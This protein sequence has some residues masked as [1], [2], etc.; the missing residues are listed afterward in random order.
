MK[1]TK[2][3]SV[4]MISG[5]ILSACSSKKSNEAATAAAGTSN[6]E[7]AAVP[8]KVITLQKTKIARTI[9]YTATVLPYEEVNMVPSMPGRIDKIYVETGDRVS[10][11]QQLFLMDR[12]QLYQSK[13][14]LSSLQKDL[15]RLDT[16]LR[17][18]SVTQQQYDQMKTQYDVLKTNVDFMDENTL[19]R[20][21]FAG[22]ITGKYFENGEMYSGTP[23]T[24]SGRSAIVTVMQVNPLKVNVAISEQFYPLIKN[25]M[26]AIV[27]AD[28]Y[29]GEIFTGRVFRKAP[30]V[31]SV[32]RS[33]IAEIELPNRN[34]MLKPGMF[35][36]VSM[37]LGEVETFVVPAAT[38]LLQEGT[39]VR[40]VF[41]E[42]QGVAKRVEVTLGKRF[43]DQLEIISDNLRESEKLITEGQAR[44]LTG[45]K[46]NIVK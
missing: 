34:E 46:I 40:Y 27:S 1:Y 18:G 42:D 16:L 7:K 35:V 30:T 23:T 17:T 43:D 29:Q 28:V 31:N 37:D 12:T 36:R 11:G 44:L 38:V 5:L 3:I 45:D 10:K 2:I 26:K 8:V 39:N 6:T 15:S 19:L 41:I 4:I 24:Q 21:P 13:V 20:A 33:F 22:V 32:T 25:G 14:Q 9:D